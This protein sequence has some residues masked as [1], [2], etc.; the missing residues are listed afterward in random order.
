MQATQLSNQ[1]GYFFDGTT[2]LVGYITNTNSIY[3][4]RLVGKVVYSKPF[5]LFRP[6]RLGYKYTNWDWSMFEFIPLQV[7]RDYESL[8]S[9]GQKATEAQKNAYYMLDQ[10][11]Q[12]EDWNLVGYKL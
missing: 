6:W 5:H 10:L 12:T 1:R 9:W 11:T 4:K 7:F 2:L 8:C 3:C